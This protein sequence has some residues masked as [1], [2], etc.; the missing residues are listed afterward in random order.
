MGTLVMGRRLNEGCLICLAV[1]MVSGAVVSSQK[2]VVRPDTHTMAAYIKRLMKRDGQEDWANEVLDWDKRNT[3]DLKRLMRRGSF[4]EDSNGQDSPV[5]R[6]SDNINGFAPQ[7]LMKKELNGFAPKRLMKKDFE[8]FSPQR[9]MKKDLQG[10]PPKRLMKKDL[11]GFP[12]KRLMKKDLDSFGPRRLMKKNAH[13][14]NGFSTRR[15]MKRHFE[16]MQ[17]F[18]PR[19]LMKKDFDGFN[20][21]RLMKKD[22]DPKRLMKKEL[23][24]TRVIQREDERPEAISWKILDLPTDSEI[25]EPIAEVQEPHQGNWRIEW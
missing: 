25:W 23:W 18:G 15:L 20:I 2:Q 16:A 24:S 19:R 13:D 12:P 22:F 3:F 21:Q 9:L 14:Q 8:G 6:D 11:Q 10:F 1:S 17:A 7:R 4:Q 5:K